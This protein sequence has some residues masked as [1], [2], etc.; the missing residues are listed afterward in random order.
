MTKRK[1]NLEISIFSQLSKH[2]RHD[3]EFETDHY[4]ASVCILKLTTSPL[5]SLFKPLKA[6]QVVE[7]L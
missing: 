2:R 6:I 3:I 5:K 1:P 7:P 4:V